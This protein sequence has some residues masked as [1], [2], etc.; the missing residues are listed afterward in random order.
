[1]CVCLSRKEVECLLIFTIISID[2]SCSHNPRPLSQV[3]APLILGYFP[4]RPLAPQDRGIQWK[5]LAEHSRIFKL[6]AAMGCCA[7]GMAVVNMFASRE[8]ILGY[9]LSTSVLLNVGAFL[10][11]D[12]MLA[13]C[14]LYMFLA[15]AMYVQVDGAMDYFYTAD[16]EYVL[17]RRD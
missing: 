7:M 14:T 5:K 8:V 1:M 2:V 15:M 17:I 6:A 16:S 3:C 10:V 13:K 9:A 11:L 4:E 12:T